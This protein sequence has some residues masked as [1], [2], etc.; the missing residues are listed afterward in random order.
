MGGQSAEWRLE[1]VDAA[2][3]KILALLLD[4]PNPVHLDADAARRLNVADREVNQV[5]PIGDDY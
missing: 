3:M 1:H 4:D 2:R 5:R